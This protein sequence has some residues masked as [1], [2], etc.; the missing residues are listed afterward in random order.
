M[1]DYQYIGALKTRA[2][3]LIDRADEAGRIAAALS[4]G[5]AEI[6]LP[7]VMSIASAEEYIDI[8]DAATLTIPPGVL[9]PAR[10]GYAIEARAV[11]EVFAE[12]CAPLPHL[13]AQ[14]SQ[15]PD[16]LAK[17]I[18]DPTLVDLDRRADEL[19]TTYRQ[20]EGE[21][22]TGKTQALLTQVGYQVDEL[23]AD[24]LIPAQKLVEQLRGSQSGFIGAE[25]QVVDALAALAKERAE[26]VIAN[27]EVSALAQATKEKINTAPL[28]AAG[29]T[30]VQQVLAK[31]LAT[32]TALEGVGERTAKRILAAAH[33][34]REEAWQGEQQRSRRIG[35][36]PTPA[37]RGLVAALAA[38][39]AA[40]PEDPTVRASALR[41]AGIFRPGVTVPAQPVAVRH[42]AGITSGAL[43]DQFVNDVALAATHPE[44]F[45][46]TRTPPADSWADYEQRT[47][48]YQSLLDTI[49][50]SAGIAAGG[51]DA[52]IVAKI[53]ALVLDESQLTE[54]YLRGYQNFG[55]KFIC[56]QKKTILGDE[57]GLGKTVQALAALA[58]LSV[59][60]EDFRALVVV[61]A[62]LM[63]NWRRET[64]KFTTLPVAIAH[65][66]YREQAIQAWQD[67]GCVLVTSYEVA[68]MLAGQ[69]GT[70]TMVIVDEA[71]FIKNPEAG[72]S[73]VVSGLIDTAEY[74]LLM[75]GTPLE[76]RVA[77]FVQLVRYVQP[78]L[79][80]EH[81]S[82]QP[83][84]PGAFITAVAPA[85]LRR[86][87][88]DV[89][90]ELPEKVEHKE[91]ITLS[92]GDEQRYRDAIASGNWM[93][94]RQACFGAGSAKLERLVE[95]CQQAQGNGRNVLIFSYF[96]EVIDTVCGALGSAVVGAITGSVE[97]AGR[98][99]MVD[100]LGTSGHVLVA[101]IG[102]GGVGLNI[103]HASVVVFCEVQVKPS[104]EDQA[105][106]RAHRMGQRNT[107]D[108]YWLLGDETVDE[109]LLELTAA[110]RA[111]F[112]SYARTS[113]SGQAAE[114]VDV[115]ET[116][117][118]EEIIAAERARLGLEED[119]QGDALGGDKAQGADESGEN[120]N[121][122]AAAGQ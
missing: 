53:K 88:T 122:A 99:L 6:R 119:H 22:L 58:H 96:R 2:A 26:A 38:Y 43:W 15:D 56:V 71:H 67:N 63:E 32:L 37:A 98:Q 114:A 83:V 102:A 116:K 36:E 74:A 108:V 16:S 42:G 94:A 120:D 39:E 55:A 49:A 85:Y 59:G 111:E 33:T 91:W 57:M 27:L 50:G 65:G 3:T 78:D 11:L 69:W 72:R 21:R 51:L 95:L 40:L 12:Y 34:L 77:E 84:L 62:S 1:T 13:I 103:Q 29:I 9:G 30:T 60:R 54:L 19:I 35:A 17:A 82:Q 8:C 121:D 44:R 45:L 76:N 4:A 75:T 68:R 115:S 118:A 10:I 47:A 46:A 105:M 48:T 87:Q 64:E 41:L 24:S 107:V 7:A 117:I 106:A 20:A 101:Q 66:P 112:D 86:N 18:T 52:S 28:T 25:Q 97:P 93:A 92:L 113:E 31:D 100:A 110:K 104:L 70:P 89:L 23:S 5:P 61:P 14:A 80:P 79:L 73:Q 109:R 81:A 90:D